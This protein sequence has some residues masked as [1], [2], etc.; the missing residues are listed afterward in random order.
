MKMLVEHIR[1]LK[2]RGH[3]C[4]AVHRSDTATRAMPPW[5]TVEANVDVV[6][7]LHERLNDIYPVHEL[8]VVVVGIFHQVPELMAGVTAP[9][10]YWEQGHEWLFGDPVRF[11]LQHNYLQQD[12][13]FHK[14][15]KL[16]VALIAVSRAVQSILA[17]EFGRHA[18]IIPNDIDCERFCPGPRALYPPDKVL[19]T[20]P[21]QKPRQFAA[22][23]ILLVGNPA[24]PLKG[25]DVAASVL[26]AVS[27]VLPLSVTWICQSQPE[28]RQ[29]PALINS[30][31][32]INL[33]ISPPQDRLPALYRGHD[34]LLFTS[35]YEAWGMP[36]LEAMASGLAVVATNCLGLSTFATHGVDCLIAEPRDVLGLARNLV[37]VLT[38]VK[39]RERLQVAARSAAVRFSPTAVASRLEMLLYSLSACSRELLQLRQ[40][41]ADDVQLA[42]TWASQ[43]CCRSA[44]KAS[45]QPGQADER[46]A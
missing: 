42:C 1:M 22:H 36:V 40:S 29:V 25:F 15:M 20:T 35:R 18:L 2:A 16:P 26:V 32:T 12:Q 9:V 4:I 37:M 33:Y 30:G 8:D 7:K 10:L 19:L 44:A 23:S 24:L 46:K 6:C 34:A 11:Q 39:L 3:T 45:A 41:C 38:D 14:V 5:T 27:K 13:L 43:T 28:A 17:H 21:G 31:L